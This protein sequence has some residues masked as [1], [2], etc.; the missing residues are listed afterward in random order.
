MNQIFSFFTRMDVRAARAVGVSIALFALVI[1]IFLVGRFVFNIEPG[2]I[3]V[4]L[5][6]AASRWY[7]LPLT[8]LAFTALSYVGAPQFALFAAT[9]L[10]FGPVAGFVYSWAGTMVSAAANFWTGRLLGADVVRRYGGD[11]VNRISAFVGKNGFWASAIIRNVPSAP[12]IVVNMAAG[13][14]QMT[15]LAFLGGTGLGILPK[16]ALVTFAGGGVI[17]LLSG[18]GLWVAAILA[19]TAFGWLV[20]MLMARKWLRSTTAGQDAEAVKHAPDEAPDGTSSL[21]INDGASHKGH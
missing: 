21:A 14:S 16:I 15:F 19:L 18:S 17:A 13:V 5:A 7:A 2:D 1:A 6:D 4:W 3:Q 10:A 9:V 20:A 11:T 8:I 12:F